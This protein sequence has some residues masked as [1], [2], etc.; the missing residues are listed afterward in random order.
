MGK[1][2]IT[3]LRNKYHGSE[4]NNMAQKQIPYL[5]NKEHGLETNKWFR[6]K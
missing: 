5:K 1:K 2:Q 4:T 3:W 6:N